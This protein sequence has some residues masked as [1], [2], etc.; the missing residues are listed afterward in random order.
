MVV[1]LEAG[2]V[3]VV[4]H[5]GKI[6]KGGDRTG[7]SGFSLSFLGLN[8]PMVQLENSKLSLSRRCIGAVREV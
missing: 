4:P 5:A 2:R 8:N 1:G 7:S 3:A 6:W